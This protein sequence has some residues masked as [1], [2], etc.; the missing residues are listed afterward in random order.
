MKVVLI[1]IIA[2]VLLVPTTIFAQSTPELDYES[3]FK[4]KKDQV[5][6]KLSNHN[7]V[8]YNFEFER[9]FS[10]PEN[11]TYYQLYKIID[12]KNNKHVGD[13]RMY[14]GSSQWWDDNAFLQEG[15]TSGFSNIIK[16]KMLVLHMTEPQLFADVTDS[17]SYALKVLV[18]EWSKETSSISSDVWF[19]DSIDNAKRNDDEKREDKI[20]IGNKE[21]TTL[22]DDLDFGSITIIVTENL[23]ATYSDYIS[24]KNEL[25]EEIFD[26]SEPEPIPEPIQKTTQS[27]IIPQQAICGT[28]TIEKDGICIVDSTK[29]ESKKSDT[30]ISFQNIGVII[31][32]GILVI[33]VGVIVMKKRHSKIKHQKI[34]DGTYYDSRK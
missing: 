30:I 16:I 15:D 3:V 31:A 17:L 24:E 4:T 5:L 2:F 9:N 20:T 22:H 34:K 32:V 18:P 13:L 10:E 26:F 12:S 27:E 33:I 1:I 19:F 29:L 14:V 21:I 6:T 23:D 11:N 7:G 28:G 25:L 8:G